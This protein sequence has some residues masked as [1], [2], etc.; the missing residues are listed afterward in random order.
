M[1]CKQST[2]VSDPEP[3]MNGSIAN[4]RHKASFKPINYERVVE[5]SQVAVFSVS[6]C[7]FC[8]ATVKT[9][10]GKKCEMVFI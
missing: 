7:G 10:K 3:G 9:L 4:Y 2:N 8:K 5:D 6:Y 1:G